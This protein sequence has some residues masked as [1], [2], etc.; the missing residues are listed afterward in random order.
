MRRRLCDHPVQVRL[1]DDR[2]I[3]FWQGEREYE[4]SAL[5][6]MVGLI[7]QE[8]DIDTRLWQ[9]RARSGG[10]PDATYELECDHGTWRMVAIWD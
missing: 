10:V 3:L 9:V 5:L 6:K 4:V 7:R 2:P 1:H 8:D